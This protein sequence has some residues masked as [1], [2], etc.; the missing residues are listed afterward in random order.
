MLDEDNGEA[1]GSAKAARTPGRDITQELLA[2]G[3][4]PLGRHSGEPG[5]RGPNSA[6]SESPLGDRVI[7]IGRD[8]YGPCEYVVNPTFPHL[9]KGLPLSFALMFHACI[10][11][12][13][14]MR[15]T[16]QQV[17]PPHRATCYSECHHRP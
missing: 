12:E 7:A 13:P 14:A 6:S 17:L 2:A 15:P 10:R 5:G 4:G 3:G 1:V 16:C 8:A 11:P 9:L